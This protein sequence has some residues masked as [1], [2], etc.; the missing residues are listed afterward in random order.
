MGAR[1]NRPSGTGRAIQSDPGVETPGYFQAV[2][3]G[4]IGLRHVHF[5]KS[6]AI[7]TAL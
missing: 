3:A 7:K 1:F 5:P 2:P 6:S 4:Q